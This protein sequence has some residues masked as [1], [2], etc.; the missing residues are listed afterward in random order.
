M[1]HTHTGLRVQAVLD[2][3]PYETGEKVSRAD[4]DGLNVRGHT[5]HPD[6]NYTVMPRVSTEHDS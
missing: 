6:W 2:T 4:F 1:T 3:R 5:F